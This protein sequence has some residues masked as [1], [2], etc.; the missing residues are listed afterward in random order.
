MKKLFCAL[1]M[2]VFFWDVTGICG[3]TIETE[4]T[5]APQ[6]TTATQEV[7][8]VVVTAQKK[9]EE[10]KDVPISMDVFS[11]TQLEDAAINTTTDLIKFSPN[12]FMKESHVEHALVIRG[13]SS[14]QSSVYSPAGFYVDDI[15]YPLHY[16]QNADLFDVERI[17]IL[18]GPQGTLYGRNSE[19][20]V[21]NIITKQPGN[22]S[23]AMVSGEYASYDTY[24]FGAS[25]KEPI[26]SDTLFFG[27]SFKLDTSDG[28]TENISNGDDTVSDWEHLSGRTTLRWTPSDPWDISFISDIQSFNDH[29]GGFRYN[30]GPYATGQYEVQRDTDEYVDQNSNSQNLRLKYTADAFEVLSVTSLLNQDLDKVNDVDM[31]DSSTNEKT[32]RFQ[33]DEQQFSQE[34]RISSTGDGTFEWLAGAYGFTEDTRL[35]IQYDIVSSSITA[36]NPVTDIDSSGGAVFAQGTYTLFEKLH[37]TAGLRFDHQEMDGHRNDDIKKTTND[38][39]LTFDEVLPKIAVN[40]D[41]TPDVMGYVSSSKGYLVGGFNWMTTSSDDRFTYDSEYTWNYEAGIKASWFSGKLVSNL[42]VFYIDITDKQVTEYDATTSSITVTNAAKAHSQGLELQVQASPA[43]GLDLFAGFGYTKS[44][45][46]DFTTIDSSST[47]QDYDGNDLTYAPRYT[48]NL[49]AQYRFANGIFCR[50]D[51]FGTD[52]FYGDTANTATQSAY[53]TLNLKLGYEQETFDLYVY[54]KNVLDQEYLTYV[55]SS[56]SY[57]IGYDGEPQVFG[58]CARIRF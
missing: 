28:Y 46:D 38:D 19:S 1:L 43:T 48:Y 2:A 5:T 6:E 21:L 16:T 23:E 9:E 3:E 29:G 11:D 53:E 55:Q 30:D 42:S 33:I 47:V 36:M 45:F 39:S 58:V 12:V 49:G 17:E 15:S 20:G 56:G 44:V 50:A 35:Q 51:V 14:F 41:I 40:Y 4:E 57:T 13:I 52:R 24:R 37:L 25:L 31:W 10:L 27:G 32:S 54:A 7:E 8:K 26:V 22:E 18:K 34:L